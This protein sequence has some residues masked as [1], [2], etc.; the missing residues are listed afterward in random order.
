M[1]A[2]GREEPVEEVTGVWGH[3]GLAARRRGV[4]P[5]GSLP[6]PISSCPAFSD[7]YYKQLGLETSGLT[8]ALTA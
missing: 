6:R 1:C 2:S 7:L 3:L 4:F 5:P 8:V